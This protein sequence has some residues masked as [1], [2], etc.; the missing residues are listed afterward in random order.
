MI[1]G[2]SVRTKRWR[3]TEWDGGRAGA[4]LYDHDRDPGE[5]HNLAQDPA[6]SEAVKQLATY[7]RPPAGDD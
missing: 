1:S 3:Y 5:H 4:E 2:R 7:V 6:H